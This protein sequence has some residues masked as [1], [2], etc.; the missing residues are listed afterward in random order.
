MLM[1]LEKSDTQPMDDFLRGVKKIADS[2]V[3]IQSAASD[4]DL[5]QYTLNTLDSDYEGLW[6][7]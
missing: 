1:N 6:M 5:I 4:M 2:L 3:T 7:L